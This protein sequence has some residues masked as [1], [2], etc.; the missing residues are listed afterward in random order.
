MGSYCKSLAWKNRQWDKE[1]LEF[2]DQ[3]EDKEAVGTSSI[4]YNKHWAFP[5]GLRFEPTGHGESRFDDEAACSRN[6]IF[7]SCSSIYVRHWF[8]RLDRGWQW[9][10]GAFPGSGRLEF[11]NM[12]AEP[13]S[14]WSTTSS[15]ILFS[16]HGYELFASIG[17]EHREHGAH[18]GAIL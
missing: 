4:I 17:R 3:K 16:W 8:T 6:P 15:S 1:L 10:N 12:A 5:I 7:F 2:V 11:R 9:T 18:A 13:A 14:S